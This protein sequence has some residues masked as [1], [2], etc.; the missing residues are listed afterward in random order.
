MATLGN[1]PA[2]HRVGLHHLPTRGQ[3]IFYLLFLILSPILGLMVNIVLSEDFRRNAHNAGPGLASLNWLLEI[4][5]F[6]FGSVLVLLGLNIT[7]LVLRHQRRIRHSLLLFGLFSTLY[8]AI[9]LVA[10][11]YGIFAYKIQSAFLLAISFATYLSLNM[12][13]LFWYWYVDYPGQVRRLHHPESPLQMSFPAQELAAL[14]GWIPGFLDYLYLTI[15]MS[16][17]LGPPEGHAIFGSKAKMLQIAHSVI[18]LVL[19]VI[20]V[21]RAINTLS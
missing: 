6:L 3:N 1:D 17:T 5:G 12:V 18:M 20:F 11:T 15:M 8:L 10:V 4:S 2:S 21:S 7:L 19:F 14:Q 16:N 13:F 9:N